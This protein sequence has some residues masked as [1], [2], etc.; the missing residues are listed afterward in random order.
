M[1]KRLEETFLQDT[2]VATKHIKNVQLRKWKLKPE[3]NTMSKMSE[4]LMS[5]TNK[6]KITSVGEDEN[7]LESLWHPEVSVSIQVL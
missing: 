7:K 4:W 3:W 2:Q 1:G 5:K 6:Q